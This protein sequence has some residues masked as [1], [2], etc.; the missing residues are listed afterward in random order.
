MLIQ[1][2][3][4]GSRNCIPWR[5]FHCVSSVLFV[6][7]PPAPY[8]GHLAGMRPVKALPTD[9]DRAVLSP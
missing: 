7:L 1:V 3:P 2:N 8:Q 5:R 9:P 6:Q 4:E